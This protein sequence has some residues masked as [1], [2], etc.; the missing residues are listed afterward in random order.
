LFFR[1]QIIFYLV[2]TGRIQTIAPPKDLVTEQN[3]KSPKRK[4][5]I[6]NSSSCFA[7]RVFSLGS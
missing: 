4:T 6:S 2:E 1:G 3:T 7:H 5:K